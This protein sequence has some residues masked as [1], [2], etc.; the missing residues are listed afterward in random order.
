MNSTSRV[1]TVCGIEINLIELTVID[2]FMRFSVFGTHVTKTS[3]N[4]SKY[5]QIPEN[6][7]NE[8]I[9]QTLC[10]NQHILLYFEPTAVVR[11]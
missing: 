4:R 8:A 6:E 10:V 11:W 9:K 1:K 7:W 3:W 5:Q 2:A